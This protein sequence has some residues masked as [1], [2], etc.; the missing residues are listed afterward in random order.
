MVSAPTS[1]LIGLKP[2]S[3]LQ[4][5][6]LADGSNGSFA[7]FLACPGHVCF[8]ADNDRRADAPDRQF[9]ANRE[10]P[11]WLKAAHQRHWLAHLQMN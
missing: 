11:G 5:E 7:P 2:A 4:H 6:M 3:L 8:P 9:S 1:T 10:I